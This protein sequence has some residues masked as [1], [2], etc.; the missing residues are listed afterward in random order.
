MENQLVPTNRNGLATNGKVLSAVLDAE[1][2]KKQFTNALGKHSDAFVASII[3]LYNADKS[4]A[5]CKTNDIVKECLKAATLKLPINKALGFSYIVVYN[6]S[7]RSDNGEWIKVPT[8]TFI[9]GYKGYIQLAMR[10]GQYRTINADVVYD[11]ELQKGNRLTGEIN[12]NG[13]KRSDKVIGYFCHFELLNGFSK[14]LYVSVDEMA[15]YAKKY[16][17]SIGRNTTVEQLIE[18]ANANVPDKRSVGWEGNFNDMAIKTVVRRLLSK[19]G[20][21]SIEMQ[22]ALVDEV[23]TEDS[24][25]DARNQ[26]SSN[27]GSQVV[28]IPA[29]EEAVP[30]M[31][32]PAATPQPVVMSAPSVAA[33][34]MPQ[35]NF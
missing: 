30:V 13:E 23:E 7:V 20:Y 33:P 24:A 19:Y 4:L 14:T 5:T 16:S 27:V 22:N 21:L 11:G 18:K 9:V 29:I 26:M 1:S 6:N 3:D 2:V 35:M 31:E 32:T 34:Q 15:A 28:D 17:P 25:L 12:L 10:T 8:P